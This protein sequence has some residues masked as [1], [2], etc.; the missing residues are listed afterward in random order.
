MIL[1]KLKKYRVFGF[2]FIINIALLFVKPELTK[3]SFNNSLKFLLE[4]IK[5]LP[6]VMILM[7]LL[8]VWIT[9]ETVE[10]HLGLESGLRGSILAIFLGTAAAGPLFTAFPIAVSLRQKGVRTANVVIFLGS[11]ATIKIPML[12][13]ESRFMGLRF[14]LLRL[15]ITIPFIFGIGYLMEKL[16][17]HNENKVI[18]P[19]ISR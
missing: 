12:I 13:M 3:V 8:E 19:I 4:V 6:P 11:W 14:A 5:I 15:A 2:V 17:I 16:L 1:E 18:G 10:S 7:G 9:R